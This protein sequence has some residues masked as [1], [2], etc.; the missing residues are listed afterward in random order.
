MITLEQRQEQQQDKIKNDNLERSY[1]SS[2]RVRNIKRSFFKH[3]MLFIVPSL[4]KRNEVKKGEQ[5]MLLKLDDYPY[6]L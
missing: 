6:Y 5:D 4:K 1:W 3:S 2:S